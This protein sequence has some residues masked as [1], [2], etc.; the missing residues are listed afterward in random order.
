MN[1][2]RTWPWRSRACRSVRR[3]SSARSS[4]MSRRTTSHPDIRGAI[5][6]SV[7]RA[8]ADGLGGARAGVGRWPGRDL[9]GRVRGQQFEGCLTCRQADVWWGGRPAAYANASR[10]AEGVLLGTRIPMYDQLAQV[11]GHLAD[12]ALVSGRRSV[13]V[14][15]AA[16]PGRPSRSSDRVRRPG[17]G[18]ARGAGGPFGRLLPVRSAEWIRGW[19]AA[20]H[21]CIRGGDVGRWKVVAKRRRVTVVTWRPGSALPMVGSG[22]AGCAERGDAGGRVPDP[23]KYGPRDVGVTSWKT[24]SSP[25]C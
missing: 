11:I 5:P 18:R 3:P 17:P 24:F 4:R 15:G 7:R 14:A 8:A 9:G 16:L 10:R 2:D 6:G 23:G 22:A 12:F 21:L 25:K 1:R 20:S 19:G 13:S